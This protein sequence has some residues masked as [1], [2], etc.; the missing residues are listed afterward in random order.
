MWQ[1]ATLGALR[2]AAAPAFLKFESARLM[3]MRDRWMSV[4]TQAS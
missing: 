3:Q 4:H 2:G 1:P